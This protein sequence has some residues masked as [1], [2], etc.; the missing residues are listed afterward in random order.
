[1]K[2]TKTTCTEVEGLLPLYVGGDL[3]KD[4]LDFV[5]GHLPG[6]TDCA[7]A[8]SRTRQARGLLRTELLDLVEGREPQLWPALR[9]QLQAEGLFKHAAS[10]APEG[11]VQSSPSKL[12]PQTVQAPVL[13]HPRWRRVAGLAASVAAVLF[14]GKMADFGG[15]DLQGPQ[16]RSAGP[17]VAGGGAEIPAAGRGFDGSLVSNGAV[18]ADLSGDKLLAGTG[19]AQ[20]TG[21]APAVVNHTGP[22]TQESGGLRPVGFDEQ[23]LGDIARDNLRREREAGQMFFLVAPSSNATP[24]GVGLVSSY[25]LQ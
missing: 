17:A 24:S 5:A 19:A 21:S 14:L 1:M 13:T 2:D 25:S 12:E 20:D 8:F 22:Q 3:E 10:G 23:S 16:D 15:G 11:S 4:Q 18:A 6:C 9:E 7:E